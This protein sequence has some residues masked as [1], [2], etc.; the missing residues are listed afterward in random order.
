MDME[1][2]ENALREMGHRLGGSLLEKL[3]NGR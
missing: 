3:L 1:A 2:T